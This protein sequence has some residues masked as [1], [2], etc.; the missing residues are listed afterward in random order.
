[1]LRGTWPTVVLLAVMM[2]VTAE[3]S[4]TFPNSFW[5]VR[6]SPLAVHISLWTWIQ[7]ASLYLTAAACKYRTW[8]LPL[9]WNSNKFF[10]LWIER[11]F[12]KILGLENFSLYGSQLGF[13]FGC[14]TLLLLHS[15]DY[16]V[17][18]LSRSFLSQA[19]S[20]AYSHHHPVFLKLHNSIGT[21]C[22]YIA[23]SL[24]QILY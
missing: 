10:F 23:F 3:G 22:S 20:L 24:S 13:T 9:N 2:M 11:W 12:V 21:W 19:F 5:Q 8:N 1:M 7:E 4:T 16:Q 14:W 17:C 15:S 18:F 6:L